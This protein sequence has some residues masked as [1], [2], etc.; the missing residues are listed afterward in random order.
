MKQDIRMTQSYQLRQQLSPCVVHS[1]QLLSM[2]YTALIPFLQKMV[3]ENPLLEMKASEDDLSLNIAEMESEDY[4][5]PTPVSDRQ[6][7]DS[8]CFETEEE[9]L[10]LELLLGRYPRQIEQTAMVILGELDT[11]GYWDGTPEELACRLSVTEETAVQALAAVQNMKPA[12]IGARSLS[13]CLLLQ[14]DDTVEHADV[15][16]T[17]ISED[18]AWT[19]G[20][21]IRQIQKKYALSSRQAQEILA[22][23]R[24][25]NPYPVELTGK[26][27]QSSYAYPEM[28]VHCRE[29]RMEI[30]LSC[31]SEQLLSVNENYLSGF[32]GQTLDPEALQYIRDCRTAAV[33][34]M[35]S[36]K[37]RDHTMKKVL[38]EI[39]KLQR[40]F[41]TR[42]AS[43]LKPMT[44]KQVAD[45]L[46]ISTSTVCRC[47]Q[48]KYIETDFGV[49]PLKSLFSAQIKTTDGNAVS[50]VA[51][52]TALRFLL[53]QEGEKRYSDRQ[54]AELLAEQGICISRRTVTKYRN[55]EQVCNRSN[56][57]QHRG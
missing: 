35:D 29:G 45:K 55:A 56:R 20:N 8:D 34:L 48:D 37:L 53:E 24:S 50:A 2:P 23:I 30:G 10:R 51:V 18:L 21:H 49:L 15:I 9:L 39:V 11:H 47:V 28:R 33:E 16:R 13:E 46:K 22:Y 5:S 6:I 7:P 38:E 4:A 41:F 27:R 3:L 1:M 26:Q 14:V 40:N 12:G 57:R 42:G 43:Y 44:L 32:S 36:L 25:L 17:L 54:L 19:A 52:K 31:R